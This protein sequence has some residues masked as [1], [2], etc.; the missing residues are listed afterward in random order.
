VYFGVYGAGIKSSFTSIVTRPGKIGLFV[1]KP[2][3]CYGGPHRYRKIPVVPTAKLLIGA[4]IYWIHHG[5]SV[6]VVKPI[7]NAISEVRIFGNWA[8]AWPAR[9]KSRR[10]SAFF[11]DELR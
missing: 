8:L 4:G 10:E 6:G 9:R 3:Y 11:W 2:Y 5:F 1:D 7:K